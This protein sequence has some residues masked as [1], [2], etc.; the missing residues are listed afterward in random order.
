M[1]KVLSLLLT[2]VLLLA[3]TSVSA[4][5][6]A[7]YP[8]HLL[9]MATYGETDSSVHASFDPADIDEE[10]N[11]LV[12]DI[13]DYDIYTTEDIRALKE[14]DTVYANGELLTVRTVDESEYGFDINGGFFSDEEDGISLVFTGDDHGQLWSVMWDDFRSMEM[15]GQA[16]YRFADEVTVSTF[17]WT[18]DYDFAGDYDTLILKA[19]EVKAYLMSLAYP[20]DEDTYAYFFC[21]DNTT[22]TLKDG[23]ITEIHV[24]W[25]PNG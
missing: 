5:D 16:E 8:I 13:Y 24:E 14:G 9:D 25:T 19:D 6:A 23:F 2:L 4:E 12:Y 7:L 3:C 15:A 20:E 21:F 17:S 10:Y 22:V 18:E 11:L 1:K